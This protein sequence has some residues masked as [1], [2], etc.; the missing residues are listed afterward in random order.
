MTGFL[1][2]SRGSLILDLIV[3]AMALVIP[4]M[5]YSLV[6]VRRHKNFER[7]RIIQISLG[8]ILGVAILAFEVDMR[9][10]GWRHLAEASPYFESL[11]F[12]ALYVHLC[13]AIPTLFLWVYTIFMASKYQISRAAGGAPRFRHKTFGRLSAYSM[14]A[15]TIT[16]WIFYYL[17]FIAM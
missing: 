1:P 9:W 12:P 4:V 17:A 11:V 5:L 7:H 3:V 15:T 13:F 6:A 8:L 10:N 2:N 16:G 14:I